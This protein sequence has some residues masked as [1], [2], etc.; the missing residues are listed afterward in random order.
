MTQGIVIPW[1]VLVGEIP[2]STSPGLEG[3]GYRGLVVQDAGEDDGDEG[4]DEAQGAGGEDEEVCG[5]LEQH[6]QHISS[7]Q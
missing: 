6:T 3:V 7:I 1:D 2:P 4:D 5:E